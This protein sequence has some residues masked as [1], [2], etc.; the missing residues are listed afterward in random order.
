M[1]IILLQSTVSSPYGHTYTR[2]HTYETYCLWEKPTEY[3]W[4]RKIRIMGC[5]KRN[6]FGENLSCFRSLE[7]HSLRETIECYRITRGASPGT[8][9]SHAYLWITSGHTQQ[10]FHPPIDTHRTHQPFSKGCYEATPRQEEM[11]PKSHWLIGLTFQHM[12]SQ[13]PHSCAFGH[14]MMFP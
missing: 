4:P 5:R 13:T 12:S 11:K 9:S 6:G 2:M 3:G 7:E 14:L 8:D 1:C 10:N